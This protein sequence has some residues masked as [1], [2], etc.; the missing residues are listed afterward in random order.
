MENKN[1]NGKLE[2]INLRDIF[3]H[4]QQKEVV[5]IEN[6]VDCHFDL[7]IYPWSATQWQ[8]LQPIIADVIGDLKLLDSNLKINEIKWSNILPILRDPKYSDQVLHLV[9]VT[10][11][12]GN[13]ILDVVFNGESKKGLLF[14]EK[15][16]REWLPPEY[17]FNIAKI[18]WEQNIAKN[19]FSGLKKEEKT[20]VEAV[21]EIE[22]KTE[23]TTPTTPIPPNPQVPQKAASA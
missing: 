21:T 11:Q 3:E 8:E 12:K 18:A 14:E 23:T 16:M 9:Y 6:G 1:G 2:R 22:K 4:A 13:N 15:D 5:R 10:I 19:L 17:I 7:T 20:I